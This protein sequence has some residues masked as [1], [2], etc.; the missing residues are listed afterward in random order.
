[1]AV[2]I[3]ARAGLA[4]GDEEIAQILRRSRRP[5]IVVANKI[6]DA[7]HEP[8]ALELHRL[9]LGDP[10]PVSALHGRG[11][12][13]LLDAIVERLDARRGRRPPG[14]ATAPTRS[15]SR[16]SAAPTSASRRS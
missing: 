11:T 6:D 5:V 3:D 16:S 2:V 7:A 1:M 13:D 8:A 14:R 9:G 12:G 15:A 10:I 4:A